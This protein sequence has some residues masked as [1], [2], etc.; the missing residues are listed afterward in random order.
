MIQR[1]RRPNAYERQEGLENPNVEVDPQGR[2]KVE[3][4]GRIIYW[5][6]HKRGKKR[7]SQ[8]T[9]GVVSEDEEWVKVDQLFGGGCV[10]I[11]EL[12]QIAGARLRLTGLR[13]DNRMCEY[14]KVTQLV[15]LAR[16]GVAGAKLSTGEGWLA[17]FSRGSIG[18]QHILMN[19]FTFGLSD[20][21]GTT[22][23][24]YYLRQGGAYRHA[25]ISSR[26]AIGALA[27]AAG[28][29]GG[30]WAAE[31]NVFGRT[32]MAS[33]QLIGRAGSAGLATAAHYFSRLTPGT[34][35]RV[36]S[37]TKAAGKNIGAA[38][39]FVRGAGMQVGFHGDEL[40]RWAMTTRSGSVAS[41]LTG[42]LL[43]F[44]PGSPGMP[45][46]FPQIQKGSEAS[47]EIIRRRM[48]EWQN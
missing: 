28:G 21:L 31:A 33:K 14:R 47:Y 19:E 12:K 41:G 42:S 35:Q 30:S 11:E 44:P 38:T 10:R 43:R 2:D 9:I 8:F 46:E 32:A 40:A 13:C 45:T 7:S 29:A 36:Y 3:R 20:K 5:I 23:A 15:E 6:T 26:V 1:D 16:Q 18:G 37:A 24:A 17:G 4:N 48:K 39:K 27:A 25:Q 22:N 34:Q